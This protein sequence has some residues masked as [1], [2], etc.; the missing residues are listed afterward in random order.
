VG[1]EMM[2][3]FQK[4]LIYRNKGELVKRIILATLI[5]SIPSLTLA[6]GQ[7]YIDAGN[8]KIYIDEAYVGISSK[9]VNL[10]GGNHHLV[11]KNNDGK[12]I[13]NELVNIREGEVTRIEL[14]KNSN[15][16][17]DIVQLEM[18]DNKYSVKDIVSKHNNIDLTELPT[19][20]KSR[21]ATATIVEM[22]P[23]PKQ[24]AFELSAYESA[25]NIKNTS[26]ITGVGLGFS[27]GFDYFK[28]ALAYISQ[29]YKPLYNADIRLKIYNNYLI[30][31]YII[32]DKSIH[33]YKLGFGVPLLS[34]LNSELATVI[35]D[36]DIIEIQGKLSLI[37]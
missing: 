6:A 29:N 1:L 12:E 34:I 2:L 9:L 28:I 23:E 27:Y 18:R 5:L 19:N 3:T 10:Q 36:K 8:N 7:L 17:D 37:I 24:L 13:T 14:G 20:N 15:V 21:Q 22:K 26:I 25:A 33:S 4:L 32:N 35:Q 30:A 16:I 11:V 31:G